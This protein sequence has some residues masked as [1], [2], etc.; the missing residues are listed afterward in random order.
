MIEIIKIIGLEEYLDLTNKFYAK[1]KKNINA[2]NIDVNLSY[3]KTE[4]LQLVSYI[5]RKKM[6]EDETF[7]FNL[8][9]KMEERFLESKDDPNDYNNS[10][11]NNILKIY[12]F[13][14]NQN[15]KKEGEIELEE[16]EIRISR[17]KQ[18]L[19]D[20]EFYNKLKNKKL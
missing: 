9:S 4:F 16:N 11:I 3:D 7:I 17:K 8:K 10:L 12:C 1:L 14:D 13:L 6:K 20:E 2:K 5:I 15:Q 18:K 19:L